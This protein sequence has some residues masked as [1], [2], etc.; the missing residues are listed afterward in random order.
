MTR[1][2]QQQPGALWRSAGRR[3]IPM[4]FPVAASNCTSFP[5]SCP[6]MKMAVPSGDSCSKWIRH[7]AGSA[8]LQSSARV[9]T[10]GSDRLARG[11]GRR[12]TTASNGRAP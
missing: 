3:A 8:Q 11:S 7:S 5:S 2:Q 9:P 12:K 4:V 10:C 6:R 1:A